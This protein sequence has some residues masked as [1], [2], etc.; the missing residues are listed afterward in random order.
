MVCCRFVATSG[1]VEYDEEVDKRD[2]F[3]TVENCCFNG[4]C[5]SK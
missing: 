2:E 4:V 1:V 5:V 3:D